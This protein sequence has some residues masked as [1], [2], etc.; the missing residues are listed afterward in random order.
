MQPMLNIAL[1]AARSAGEKIVRAS[2]RMDLVKVDEKGANDFVT[3]VDRNAEQE[4]ISIIR[5][6]YPEH[7]FLGEESGSTKPESETVWIIDPLDGTTNFIR[8]IP[9]Y[10]V[11]IGCM[12][13]GKL[14]HAIVYNPVTREEFTASRGYGAQLNGRR[15]RVTARTTLDGALIGTGIPFRHHSEELLGN[16]L[17]TLGELASKTAGIRRPGSAAL[18]LAYVAAGR[19][20][21]FW[22]TGLKPWDMA[23]GALLITE[24]GGLVSDFSGGNDFLESGNI[25]CGNP[26]CFKLV[27]QIVNSNNN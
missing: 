23:A 19:Y 9:H 13:K 6:A 27:L 11:S 15:L 7:G 14:E 10:A 8:G 18:D 25:V 22:E 16:Y 17:K 2:D 1:R 20:D 24:A 5:K 26:K 21:A 4:I 3:D 12:H